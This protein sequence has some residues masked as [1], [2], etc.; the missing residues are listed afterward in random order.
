MK[1]HPD[2]RR[3][4]RHA[5]SVRLMLLAVPFEIGAA[6]LPALGGDSL[7]WTA[8]SAAL[9]SLF[10]TAAFVARFLGQKEFEDDQAQI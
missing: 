10:T 4:L 5:W 3:I 2:W 6:V 7:L 1:L 9:A 8:L